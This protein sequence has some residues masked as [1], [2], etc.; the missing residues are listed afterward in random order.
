MQGWID[1]SVNR[2]SAGYTG[3]TIWAR[4]NFKST[5]RVKRQ[6]HK[7][8]ARRKLGCMCLKSQLFSTWEVFLIFLACTGILWPVTPHR[9]AFC[10]PSGQIVIFIY[11]LIAMLSALS[12]PSQETCV[13]RMKT[14]RQFHPS[15]PPSLTPSSR[16][17]D[18]FR[19]K[20]LVQRAAGNTSLALRFGGNCRVSFVSDTKLQ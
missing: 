13:K 17:S 18:D 10:P 3:E 16:P 11:Q 5:F 4:L 6:S 7:H 1:P 20:H 14:G 9:L 2:W 19:P 15:V 8:P 12:P